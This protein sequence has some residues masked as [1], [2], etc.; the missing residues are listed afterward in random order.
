M[1]RLGWLF[2][3]APPVSCGF[4]RSALPDWPD[5]CGDRTSGV[6]GCLVKRSKCRA[7]CCMYLC[8]SKNKRQWREVFLTRPWVWKISFEP[9]C[10]VSWHPFWRMPTAAWL[11]RTHSMCSLVRRWTEMGPSPATYWHSPKRRSRRTGLVSLPYFLSRPN[12]PCRICC[13]WWSFLRRWTSGSTASRSLLRCGE[14]LGK[15]ETRPALWC[16]TAPDRPRR[17]PFPMTARRNCWCWTAWGWAS[18]RRGTM[19]PVT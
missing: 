16:L 1:L 7:V 4:G 18:W 19:D 13:W 6:T 2:R 10:P 12:P 8:S 11:R 9:G 15:V 5:P 14:F 3:G 17:N